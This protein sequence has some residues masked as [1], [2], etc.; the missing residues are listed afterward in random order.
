MKT[1][2][3]HTVEFHQPIGFSCCQC[4]W[5]SN[6]SLCSNPNRL[7]CP[8]RTIPRCRECKILFTDPRK[9]SSGEEGTE[10]RSISPAYYSSDVGDGCLVN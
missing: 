1:S 9:G 5:P 2:S 7:D 3:I 10:E 4:Q 6:G 8:H